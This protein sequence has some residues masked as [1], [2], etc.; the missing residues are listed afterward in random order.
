MRIIN[1]YKWK[2][3]FLVGLSTFSPTFIL[4]RLPKVAQANS[5]SHQVHLKVS[6]ATKQLSG[7]RWTFGLHWRWRW[8]WGINWLSV[9]EEMKISVLWSDACRANPPWHSFLQLTAN[10]FIK[11]SPRKWSSS[12]SICHQTGTEIKGM[13]QLCFYLTPNQIYP[14]DTQSISDSDSEIGK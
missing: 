5:A 1:Y 10:N 6:A 4:H 13:K 2:R 14:W 7:N 11:A 12:A 3:H 8:K 9:K